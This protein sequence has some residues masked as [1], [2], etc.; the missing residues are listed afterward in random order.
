MPKDYVITAATNRRADELGGPREA[1]RVGWER[2][3]LVQIATVSK[4]GVEGSASPLE[5]Q[6]DQGQFVDLDR[7]SI[8][9]LIRVLKRARDQAFGRDE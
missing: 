6:V 7:Q 4:A 8:N 5:A 3:R 1:V 2:D 9:H